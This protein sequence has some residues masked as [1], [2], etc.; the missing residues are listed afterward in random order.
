MSQTGVPGR[1]VGPVQCNGG[2]FGWNSCPLLG[3]GGGVWR[4][5]GFSP[6]DAIP[7][8]VIQSSVVV[9]AA[10]SLHFPKWSSQLWQEGPAHACRSASSW[11][12]PCCHRKRTLQFCGWLWVQSGARFLLSHLLFLI[13]ITPTMTHTHTILEKCS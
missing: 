4:R 9:T 7:P 8:C 2:S 13:T 12:V 1:E 5:H 6:Q 11:L 3:V 10:L